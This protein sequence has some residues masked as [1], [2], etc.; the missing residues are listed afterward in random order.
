MAVRA[1]RNPQLVRLAA[2]LVARPTVAL[3]VLPRLVDDAGD[4]RTDENEA[5]DDGDA[6]GEREV[7]AGVGRRLQSL[8]EPEDL[9]IEPHAQHAHAR[10]QD[11][12]HACQ[13]VRT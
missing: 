1:V 2:Q 6:R 8:D 3:A 5:T 4:S 13:L 11:K 9:A 10:A 7:D 12:K